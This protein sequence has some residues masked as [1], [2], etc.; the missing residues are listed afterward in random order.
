MRYVTVACLKTYK[1]YF[2]TGTKK[3]KKLKYKK[4]M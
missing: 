4:E 2:N 1:I 3:I